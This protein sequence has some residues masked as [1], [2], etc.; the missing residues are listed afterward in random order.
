MII[1]KGSKKWLIL[2]KDDSYFTV[3]KDD[4]Q[5]TEF[6]EN[7][8]NFEVFDSEHDFKNRCNELNI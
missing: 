6:N 3:I 5:Q 1:E 8:Y 2:N 4:N 7:I